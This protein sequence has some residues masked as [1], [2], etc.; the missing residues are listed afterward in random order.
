M[1]ADLLRLHE[2]E[3]EIRHAHLSFQE[4]LSHICVSPCCLP[5]SVIP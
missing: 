4:L 1:D 3:V 2:S 5:S